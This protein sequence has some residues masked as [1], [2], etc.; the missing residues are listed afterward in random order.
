MLGLDLKDLGR[1]LQAALRAALEPLLLELRELKVL[2]TRG[3][4]ANP[5]TAQPWYRVGR[6]AVGP[7]SNATLWTYTPPKGMSA[8]VRSLGNDIVPAD[9]WASG[10]PLA[11]GVWFAVVVDRQGLKDLILSGPYGHVGAR[12]VL[13]TV[14]LNSNETLSVVAY[15]LHAT[16]TIDCC[17]DAAGFA[18]STRQG[19]G[20]EGIGAELG[21]RS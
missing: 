6:A 10:T 11:G 3:Q 8:V 20:L 17:C 19:A 4:L 18:F 2:V 13:E 21:G 16:E 15:N 1:T 5:D 7:A 12:Q 9:R 14:Q